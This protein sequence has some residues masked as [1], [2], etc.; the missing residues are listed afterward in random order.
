MFQ[1]DE[2]TFSVNDYVDKNWAPVADPM[3]LKA[4]YQAKPLVLVCGAISVEHGM[5]HAHIVEKTKS[6][7]GLDSDDMIE[8]LRALRAKIPDQN[9]GVFWDNAS[10][11]SSKRTRDEAARLGIELCFNIRY[12]PTTNGVEICWTYLKREYRKLVG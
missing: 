9:F 5:I 12:S 8:F 11:H 4:R 2:V 1:V 7:F 3:L 10:M 6:K